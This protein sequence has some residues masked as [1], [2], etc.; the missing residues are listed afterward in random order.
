MRRFRLLPLLA[1]AVLGACSILPP[2]VGRELLPTTHS[3]YKTAEFAY[4]QLLERHV[5]K[6]GSKQLLI[7]ALDSVDAFL[8]K[9]NDAPVTR[10]EFTGAIESDF[11][12][13][14]ATLDGAIAKNGKLDATLMERAATDG[15]AKSMNECHTY[16]L[17]PER[18]KGFNQGPTQ[19]EGIGAQISPGKPTELPEISYV[20]PSSPAEKAGVRAGDRIKTVEDTDVA[21]FTP[22]EVAN[23][24]KGPEGTTVHLVL[25]RGGNDIAFNIVRGKIVPPRVQSRTY[26]NGSIAYVSVAQLNGDV[27]RQ[28][29]DELTKLLTAGATTAILDLR[30]DPGGDLSAAVDIGSIFV[31]SGVLVY[32]IGRDG[33]RQAVKTND[34]WYWG[35]QKPLV[36]LVNER[37]ASGSEIIAAGV[38][39]NGVGTIIGNKTA[40]CVGIGQPRELPDGGLLLITLARMQDAK[41]GAELNGDGR[42]V[43]PDKVVPLDSA[44]SGDTQLDAAVAFLRS[45]ARR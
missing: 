13:F 17:D 35:T 36:V 38:Q 42:G 39:A 29:S 18:A 41:T 19:Y 3:S 22:E 20:F 11:S 26:E 25:L 33:S 4:H 40:G 16:Y 45:Q 28:T 34:R 8:K 21:G 30:N 9:A 32:Q 24:I 31:K 12:K 5:D 6:P 27:T 37:S 1:A 7:G 43:V 2:D 10:P 23:R 44:Q 15:M 14:G